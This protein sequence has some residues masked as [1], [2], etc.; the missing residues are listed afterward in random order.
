MILWLQR[1]KKE[2]L[3]RKGWAAQY[4]SPIIE[5]EQLHTRQY[6]GLWCNG[7]KKKRLEISGEGALEFLQHLTT[8]TIDIPIGMWR[9]PNASELAGIKDEIKVIRTPLQ[10]SLFF[11]QEQLKRAD[12]KTSACIQPGCIQI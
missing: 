2:H 4:W 12:K 7:S 11:A 1:M 3:K 5:A 9:I 10:H 8:S 6:A